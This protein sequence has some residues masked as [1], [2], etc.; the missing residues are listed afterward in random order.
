[1]YGLVIGNSVGLGI[2]FL[3][4]KFGFITLDEA[5]Y[6]L[7]KAPV[8]IHLP[9]ILWLNLGTFLVTVFFLVLPTLIVTRITPVRAL[10]FD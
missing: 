8:D 7:D 6:Y 5:N 1:L 4:K 2:A 9:T 3:Q 10:R